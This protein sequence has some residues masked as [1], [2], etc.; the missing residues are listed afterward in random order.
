MPEEQVVLPLGKTKL[1]W[2]V[3]RLI[4]PQLVSAWYSAYNSAKYDYDKSENEAVNRADL[5]VRSLGD[6]NVVFDRVRNVI[7][8]FGQQP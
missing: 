4:S 5:A 6:I 7:K 3:A 2:Q 1:D 8:F